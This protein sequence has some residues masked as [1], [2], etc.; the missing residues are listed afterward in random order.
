MIPNLL[1]LCRN[2]EDGLKIL[3][4]ALKILHEA[5]KLFRMPALPIL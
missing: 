1:G 3:H 5:S 4:Y 2:P